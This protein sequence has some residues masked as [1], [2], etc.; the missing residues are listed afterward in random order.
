MPSPTTTGTRWVGFHPARLNS[1]ACAP[2]KRNEGG[3][4]LPAADA[5]RGGKPTHL[6]LRRD[7]DIGSQIGAIMAATLLL[8]RPACRWLDRVRQQGK[9]VGRPNVSAN[10]KEA[11]R[12][13]AGQLAEAA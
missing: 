5:L 7:V 13:T 11:I 4:R 6:P 3:C 2:Y 1:L 9:K 12:E 10:V 8:A